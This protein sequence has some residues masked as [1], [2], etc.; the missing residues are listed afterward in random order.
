VR[1]MWLLAAGVAVLAAANLFVWLE[2]N[3]ADC[4]PSCSFGQDLTGLGLIVLPAL[5]VVLLLGALVRRARLRR[6]F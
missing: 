1:T 5:A 3:A 6:R 4:H 2:S